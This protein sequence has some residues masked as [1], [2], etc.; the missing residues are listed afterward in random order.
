MVT[1]L[2][3]YTTEE[4]RSVVRFSWAIALNT[5]DIH[6][7]IFPIYDGKCLLRKAVEKFSQGSSKLADDEE[8]VR[9]WLRQETKKTCILRVSMHW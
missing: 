5:K 1:V 9:R 2:E 4:Q 7:E 8:D 6:K 3:E